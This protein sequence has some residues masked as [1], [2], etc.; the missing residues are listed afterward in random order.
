VG[1]SGPSTAETKVRGISRPAVDQAVKPVSRRCSAVTAST[2]THRSRI[3]HLFHRREEWTAKEMAEVLGLAANGLYYHLRLLER[4]GLI[5]VAG[6]VARG[7]MTERTFRARDLSAR[8]TWGADDE[9][10]VATY[11]AA[12]LEAAKADVQE[13]LYATW[14]DRHKPTTFIPHVGS[15]SFNT[16]HGEIV[17]FRQR[18]DDL[19]R[20]FRERSRNLPAPSDSLR[21]LV[22]TYALRDGDSWPDLEPAST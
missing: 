2:S 8:V 18:L 9:L 12:I 15:P 22:L 4:A 10:D 16:T 1:V 11:M 5:E 7:R 6:R 21:R 17:E 19:V 20:E 13:R 3:I 14:P